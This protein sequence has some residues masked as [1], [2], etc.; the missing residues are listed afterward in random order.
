VDA[1]GRAVVRRTRRR[2]AALSLA[3][4]LLASGCVASPNV[5]EHAEGEGPLSASTSSGGTSVLAPGVTPWHATFGAML[6]CSNEPDADIVLRGIRVDGRVQATAVTPFL[7]S[8]TADQVQAASRREAVLFVPIYSITGHP[9]RFDQVYASPKP[10]AGDF[11]TAIDGH[12]VTQRCRIPRDPDA[13]FTELLLDVESGRSG[14]QIDEVFIDYTVDGQQH[15]L[16]VT[17]TMVLCGTQTKK[18]C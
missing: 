2:A 5:I 12:E 9:P 1:S 13:G 10:P 8:V 14:A 17:W 7:R 15:T 11:T 16:L 4:V 18:H 3:S 6:L